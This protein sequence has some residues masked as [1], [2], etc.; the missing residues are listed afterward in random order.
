MAE[1]APGA[2]VWEAALLE[3]LESHAADEADSE[4]SYAELSSQVGAGDI[5]FLMDLIL[6]DERRHHRWMAQLADSVRTLS[7]DALSPPIPSLGRIANPAALLHASRQFLAVERSDAKKLRHLLRELRD[8]E[9]TTL[10]AVLVRMMLADTTKH[11]E[12]LRFIEM[13]AKQAE[14][15]PR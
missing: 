2:S 8:V 13:R 15:P 1:K 3:L 9:D 5:K 10:W 4:A 14:K 11:I 7:G 12:I 6:D